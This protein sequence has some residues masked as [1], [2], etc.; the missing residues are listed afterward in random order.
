MTHG[1]NFSPRSQPGP[2]MPFLPTYLSPCS[3]RPTIRSPTHSLSSTSGCD[4]D[5][6]L[7]YNK[8]TRIES[9]HQSY[10]ETRTA[11]LL[12]CGGSQWSS[13]KTTTGVY[14]TQLHFSLALK[15][16]DIKTIHN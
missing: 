3:R 7:Q 2:S 6:S 10:T 9:H 11:T 16:L 14:G 12:L 8:E 13:L 1:R 4:P 5:K 15:Q